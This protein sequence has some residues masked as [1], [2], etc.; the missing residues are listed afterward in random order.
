MYNWNGSTQ[1]PNVI[2]IFSAPNYCDIYNN[3]GAILKID[4]NK[5][6][7]QQYSYTQHPF[8]LPDFINLFTWS[9]PFVIEKLG[10]I[11]Y[12]L[13]KKSES[14]INEEQNNLETYEEANSS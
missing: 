1:F 12:Y 5:L 14:I 3:K 6:D 8:I 13:I 7:I 2:T 4:E 10:E 11:L 9:F